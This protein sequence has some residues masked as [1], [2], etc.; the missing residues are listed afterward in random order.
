MAPYPQYVPSPTTPWFS[1]I[2]SVSQAIAL[3]WWPSLNKKFIFVHRDL[4]SKHH[5][6]TYSTPSYTLYHIT[7]DSITWR[8]IYIRIDLL[9]LHSKQ[10]NKI[11][12]TAL[13]NAFINQQ[14]KHIRLDRNMI[15]KKK[16]FFSVRDQFSKAMPSY[17]P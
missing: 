7:L 1:W 12:S 13:L 3:H 14:S 11:N 17:S 4:G 9:S 6:P 5:P 8:L 16:K 15:W 2:P 10:Y